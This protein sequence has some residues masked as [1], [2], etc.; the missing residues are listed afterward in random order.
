MPADEIEQRVVQTLGMR[1]FD[2]RPWPVIGVLV[3]GHD[4]YV[5]GEGPVAMRVRAWAL[6]ALSFAGL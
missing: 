2:A 1:T 5:G 3:A 6:T 4:V